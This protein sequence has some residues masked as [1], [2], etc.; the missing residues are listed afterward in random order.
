MESEEESEEEPPAQTTTV[1]AAPQPPLHPPDPRAADRPTISL[2]Q[3]MRVLQ[4]YGYIAQSIKGVTSTI[5]REI[6]S[7][8]QEPNSRVSTSEYFIQVYLKNTPQAIADILFMGWT[9]EQVAE[10]RFRL[11]T[12]YGKYIDE[13]AALH[14]V[15]PKRCLGGAKLSKG[16]AAQAIYFLVAP[17]RA[18]FWVSEA[19]EE[20]IDLSFNLG[21]LNEVPR[22]TRS[23]ARPA[24]APPN[25]LTRRAP[26][27][28]HTDEAHT[29]SP[30][31]AQFGKRPCPRAGRH[32]PARPSSPM[33]R[34]LCSTGG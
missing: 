15:R 33:A 3:A 22:I 30:C 26:C 34:A 1:V 5:R 10:N 14:T 31:P 23:P 19:G 13:V 6:A 8:M 32:G 24:R 16:K 7:K 12:D 28:A 9:R 17:A 20:Y 18:D 2:R 4:H 27:R 25:I 21:I 11:T 29:P